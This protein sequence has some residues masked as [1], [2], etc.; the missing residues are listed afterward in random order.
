MPAMKKDVKKPAT[1]VAAKG[2]SMKKTP[3]PKS[4]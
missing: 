3:M 1:K 2:S 4:K